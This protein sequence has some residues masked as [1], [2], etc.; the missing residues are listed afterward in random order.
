[1]LRVAKY[2]YVKKLLL[3]ISILLVTCRYIYVGIEFQYLS[4]ASFSLP[5]NYLKDKVLFCCLVFIHTSL[6]VLGR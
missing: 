2:W 1:M 6:E 5:L 3:E 4:K